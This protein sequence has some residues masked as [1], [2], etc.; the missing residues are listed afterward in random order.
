MMMVPEPWSNHESMS[1]E[2]KAFYEYHSTLMEP[3]DGPAALGF[4]DGVKIGA[5]LDRNGL[6]PARYYVTKDDHIILGSEAGTVVIPPEDILYK[7]RLRPGRM[8]LVD[9]EKGRI[10]SDEEVKAEIE[11][12]HPYREWLNEHLVDLEDLPDAPELPNRTMLP[13]K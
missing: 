5:V 10:I 2:R 12:E 8:L 4:T 13:S 11:T 7:D 6:R 3:W 1:D 9:T